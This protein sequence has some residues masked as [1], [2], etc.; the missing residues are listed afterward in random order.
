METKFDIIVNKFFNV[1]S[2]YFEKFKE[3]VHR[4]F[5][6]TE[7]IHASFDTSY[8]SS[9]ASMSFESFSIDRFVSYAV[10]KISEGNLNKISHRMLVVSYLDYLQTEGLDSDI[11]RV[12]LTDVLNRQSA[13][14]RMCGELLGPLKKFNKKVDFKNKIYYFYV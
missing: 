8:S 14:Y 13:F 4:N 12:Y 2:M 3:W 6:K 10:S 11:D 7:V 1:I 9:Y 5:G